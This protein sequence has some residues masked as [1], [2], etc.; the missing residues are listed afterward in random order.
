M[1]CLPELKPEPKLRIAARLLS[2]RVKYAS[3]QILKNAGTQVKKV[4][5]WVSYNPIRSWS[6][7]LALRLHGAGAERNFFASAALVHSA[8]FSW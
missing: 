8:L 3:N 2:V 7:N 4:I 1:N 6:R 5:F